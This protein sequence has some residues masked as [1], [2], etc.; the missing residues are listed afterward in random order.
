MLE[1]D[2][3]IIEADETWM[4]AAIMELGERERAGKA[5]NP[6]ILEYL[7]SVGVDNPTDE[8]PWC[9]AFVNWVLSISGIEGTNK[10]NARSWLDWGLPYS[11]PVYGAI[12]VLW[13]ESVVSW[14]GHVGFF[15]KMVDSNT[16]RLLGGN[17]LN[18]VCAMDYSTSCVLGYR[19]PIDSRTTTNMLDCIR[20]I[21]NIQKESNGNIQHTKDK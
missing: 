6:R 13:R 9:S 3:L 1:R 11:I 16:V 2:N 14:K 19:W 17:Q 18:S 15:L 21:R 20:E 12:A 8:T 10:P 5:H 7:R 4:H